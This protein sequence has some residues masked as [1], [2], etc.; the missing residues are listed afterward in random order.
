MLY[1]GAAIVSGTDVENR[2]GFTIN[3]RLKTQ[4]GFLDRRTLLH[5]RYHIQKM[6]G[7]GGMGAVYLAKDIKD[8]GRLCAVKEMS[9]SMVPEEEQAQAIQNF[10]IEAKILWALN[11][12]NLPALTGFFFQNQRYFLVM[13]YIDGN[14]LEELLER[15]R[16]PF[17]ERRVLGWARQL[18]D[19]LEYLHS[20]RPPIIFRDFKPGN[21]MFTRNGQIKL[22]D[23]GI[24]RFFRST[25][26]QDTQVLGTPG[27]A[28]PEQYGKSQTDERSDIYALGMTLFH[29]LTN[30]LSEKGFGLDD[31]RSVNPR[32]S[33]MVARA[34][35][36]ATRI[37][38]NERYENVAAFRRALLEVGTF[39]F[40]S[41]DVATT[42]D[43]LAEL[44]A[45]YPEEAADYLR[46]KEIEAWLRDIGEDELADVALYLDTN[47][48][49]PMEA[50]DQFINA[51]MGKHA[52]ASRH[53]VSSASGSIPQV[54]DPRQPVPLPPVQ[55]STPDGNN[56][57][58]NTGPHNSI[59][60][61]WPTPRRGVPLQVRPHKLDFGTVY[62]GG[63]SAALTV[64]ISGPQGYTVHGT[65]HTDEPWIHVDQDH[66]DAVST[67]VNVQINSLKL[68]RNT[69]YTGHIIISSSDEDRNDIMV[70]VEADIQGYVARNRRHPGR[71]HG[72][73]LDDDEFEDDNDDFSPIV[74][75][76]TTGQIM[77]PPVKNIQSQYTIPSPDVM[78]NPVRDKY[79]PMS[80][81]GSSIPRWEPG[82]ITR[83]QLKWQR[84]AL[85]FTASFMAASWVY[86]MFSQIK[87]LPLSPNPLF[88]LLL[89]C[90]LP[91]AMLGALT[92]QWSS[93]FSFDELL[94]RSS[95]SLFCTL[96][97][98]SV[99][100][101]AWQ[102]AVHAH[103][104]PLQLLFI[105]TVAALFAAFGAY[106]PPCA[107]AIA[108]LSRVHAA[109]GGV[110]W[111]AIVL[112]APVGA[113]FGYLLTF[114]FD[115]GIFTALGILVG[116]GIAGS[117]M[118]VVD[119]LL[120]S[121]SGTHA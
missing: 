47:V 44:C 74:A 94:A 66:F 15:N 111:R 3:G 25:S 62:S 45:N 112:F 59:R 2:W 77:V 76:P 23:F 38:P 65:I 113:I 106:G 17:T 92:V 46:D 50:V 29:L 31:V 27:Y 14:T 35:E 72:A 75:D 40:E 88:I 57:S 22:I 115:P 61:H 6:I 63:L 56:G 108:A 73:D 121:N 91:A 116:A 9:L 41:G 37:D 55:T 95:T 80:L 101:A 49:D 4:T 11:H 107:S 16:A 89:I 105:L 30:T 85:T 54:H 102:F 36:K 60:L 83:R 70:D 93:S 109:V 32:I 120:K 43:E 13:E 119:Y 34:L 87:P 84:R 99:I 100:E 39:V 19:V 96:V 12:P 81:N 10:K 48:H 53:K 58:G 52:Y 69:H 21:I 42:P 33:P 68:Q 98:V 117:L 8:Q 103:P 78:L 26:S 24:A 90:M 114:G 86:T 18:C 71:T 1:W 51:V 5:K 110:G 67:E 64:W 79:T 82:P 104:G 28:P 7:Q 97:G 20:Q 118:W